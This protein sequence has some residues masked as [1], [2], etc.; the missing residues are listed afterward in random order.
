MSVAKQ[1]KDCLIIRLHA[2]T[3]HL[4]LLLRFISFNVSARRGFSWCQG[5]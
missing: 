5:G 1:V 3:E 2:E 4:Q